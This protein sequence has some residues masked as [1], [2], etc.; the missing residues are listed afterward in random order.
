MLGACS[1]SSSDNNSG[2]T[3]STM[4]A[5][6]GEANLAVEVDTVMLVPAQFTSNIVSNGQIK[7]RESADV[8]FRMAEVISDVMVKNGQRVR[9]GQTLAVLDQ[10]KLQNE[11]TKNEAALERAKLELQDVLISQGFDP[12]QISAIPAEV[13]R[14]ARVKSGLDEAEAT[15]KSTLNEI[16]RTNVAAPF[17]GVVANVKGKRHD[18]ASTS[19]PFCRIIN[20]RVMDVQF[21]VLES[22]AALVALG[23]AVEISPFNRDNTCTGH[24]TEINPMVDENGQVLLKASVNDAKGL[25]DGMNVRVKISHNVGESL[26]VPK[27]AVV[28][29]TGRP[30]VFTYTDGKAMW[31]YVTLGLENLDSYEITEGL[32]PGMTVIVAG[33]ENLAHESPVKIKRT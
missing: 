13:I 32:T 25:L 20:D 1:S 16:A 24:I 4:A 7:A 22:E 18:M 10:F 2:A 5:D 8:F 29:R 17:D 12:A 26:L 6:A 30:V 15:H 23:E 9:Q 28:L 19:E 3:E 31:N 11:K 27:S 21:P 33:N 14:L